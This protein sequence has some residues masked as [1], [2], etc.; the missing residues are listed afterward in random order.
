MSLVRLG[1]P[2]FKCLTT[3][4]LLLKHGI[5]YPYLINKLHYL[6]IAA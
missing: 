2:I 4:V 6:C 1:S 3:L 5:A